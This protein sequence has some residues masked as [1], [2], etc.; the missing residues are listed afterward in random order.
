[1]VGPV[2][3]LIG[4]LGMAQMFGVGAILVHPD[5]DKM[6][7]PG[8]TQISTLPLPGLDHWN[9]IPGMPTPSGSTLMEVRVR[10]QYQMPK[11]MTLG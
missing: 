2:C 5:G 3:M 4:L 8:Q 6:M 7:H 9:L 1:M 10:D 11:E